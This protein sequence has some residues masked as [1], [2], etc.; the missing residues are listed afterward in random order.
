MGTGII[1]W[2]IPIPLV[3]ETGKRNSSASAAGLEFKAAAPGAEL[4]PGGAV[5]SFVS[6]GWRKHAFVGP[7]YG[8]HWLG[9]G[10]SR[11]PEV[12]TF[13]FGLGGLG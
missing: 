8:T 13:P 5:T 2:L 10:T 4:V 6:S 3:L 7:L 12:R 1:S 11:P 9:C